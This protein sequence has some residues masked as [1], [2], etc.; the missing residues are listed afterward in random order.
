M[1]ENNQ[2]RINCFDCIHLQITW[3]PEFLNTSIDG[4][5]LDLNPIALQ[6]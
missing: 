3:Q 1:K 5:I 6:A 4:I 2:K